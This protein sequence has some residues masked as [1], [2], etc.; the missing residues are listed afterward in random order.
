MKRDY[1]T[2]PFFW[3]H[4]IFTRS[5]LPHKISK[6]FWCTPA[7]WKCGTW[8]GKESCK[9]I[10]MISNWERMY[11]FYNS[12][13]L[14]LSSF[15]CF[16]PILKITTRIMFHQSLWNNSSLNYATIY[17]FEKEIFSIFKY[18]ST[19][20]NILLLK[21]MQDHLYPH[22]FVRGSPNFP[23]SWLSFNILRDVIFWWIFLKILIHIAYHASKENSQK[24]P[25]NL[26]LLQIAIFWYT[27]GKLSTKKKNY[28]C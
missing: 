2:T 7:L 1:L 5:T 25:K 21:M 13:F 17:I 12:H 11:I 3:G 18:F 15:E 20:R 27:V 9:R 28:V 10:K 23:L 22:F 8:R 14:L 26:I 19:I 6:K 4:E 16:W 24:E